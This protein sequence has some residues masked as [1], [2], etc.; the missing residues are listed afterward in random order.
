MP[1]MEDDQSALGKPMGLLLRKMAAGSCGKMGLGG[2]ALQQL[3]MN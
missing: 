2:S 1:G 3:K